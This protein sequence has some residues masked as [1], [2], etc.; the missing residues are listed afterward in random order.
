VLDVLPLTVQGKVDR[1]ALPSPD[2]HAIAGSAYVEP[3][4]PVERELARIWAEV[5]G[6]DRV[7]VEDN[8]FELG[9]DSILS[10]RVTSRLRSAL[11]VDLSPRMLFTTPTVAGLATA[12]PSD[13]TSTVSAIPVVSRSG[14]LPLSFAQQRLW[15]LH[16][17]DPDSTEYVSPTVLRMRGGLDVDALGGALTA[18]VTRHESLRTTIDEVDGKGTQTVH[19]PYEVRLQPTDVNEGELSSVLVEESRRP[20]DLRTGPL[21]RLRLL[22]LAPDEHL[23][24]MMMH[25]IVTDG[26]SGGVITDEL[27]ALYRAALSGVAHELPALPVQYADFA[28]WQREQFSGEVADEQLDYWRGQ[29]AGVPPLELP[30]DRPRPAVRTNNGA[31]LAFTVPAAVGYRLRRLAQAHDSTLFMA[32]AGAC[33]VLLGRWSRQHDVALGTVTTGRERA[34]LENLIGFFV[35]TLVLRSTVDDTRSFRAHLTAMRDT[36][37]G[38]F[39]HQDIPFERLVDELEPV[40]DVSRTPLFQVMVVLQN[41]FGEPMRLPGLEVTDVEI[42]TVTANFDLVIGFQELPDGRLHGALTYNTDLFDAATIDRMAAHLTILLEQ[43]AADPDRPLLGYELLTDDERRFVV[44]T[45]N[46]TAHDVPD[47]TLP[48][49]LD[50]QVARTPDAPA[51]VH[52]GGSVS[53]AEL[54]AWA[55]R[56]A[57]KL[58]SQ[59]VGP[60]T[61]VAISLP[62][63]VEMIVAMLAVIKA[64][65]AYLP[66]EPDYPAERVAFMVDETR[67]AVVLD[68]LDAVRAADG[69]PDSSPQLNGLSPD[70]VVYVIYTSGSTGRPKGVTITHGGL[71]NYLA[72]AVQMYPSLSELAI[73]HSP[74]SFDLTVT[75]LFGP[76]LVG[77]RIWVTDLTEN[78]VGTQE[79]CGFLKV[80]PSHIPLLK[81]LP[82][83]LS[84][85]GDLVVG[86]E[87]LLGEV[88]TEF[89]REHPAAVNNEYGQTETTVGC[90]ECRFE[91]GD[92]VAAGPLAIGRP[93]WNVRL[94]VLDESLRPAPIGVVG[95]IYVAGDGVARG[96]FNRPGLTADR[97][98]ACPFGAPGERMY[99]SGDLGRK[100]ADGTFECMGRIDDQVKVRGYRVELGEIEAALLRHPDVAK[101]AVTVK[102]GR[103]LL[104]YVVPADTDTS[105]LTD[106]LGETLPEYMLPSVYV[107]L[108]ALPLTSNGKLDRD[109]LPDPER[110]TNDTGYVA[111]DGPIENAL[112]AIWAE[113]LGMERVSVQDNFFDLGGDSILSI[114][115]VSRARKAG[116]RLTTKDMFLRQTIAALAPVVTAVELEPERTRPIEGA[117]PLT[118]IQRWFFD[119]RPPNPHHFNQSMLVE[120]AADIQDEAL[121]RALEALL[122]HHDALRMRYERV[123]EDW[124]QHYGPVEAVAY[125]RHDVPDEARWAAMEDMADDVHAGLDLVT[126][127]LVRAVRFDMGEESYL[128]LAV[129][130]LVVDSVSWRIVL[131]D[132]NTAYDQATHGATIDLGG[133]TTSY[134]QWATRLIEHV[135]GGHFDAEIEHWAEAA[136]ADPL[137][138]DRQGGGQETASRA[139][140]VHVDQQA[141]NALLR[142]APSVY[143]TGINDVLLS[144]LAWA[145]SSW[146][147]RSTVSIDLE[148]HGREDIFEGVDLSRTVG[149]F[150]TMFPVALDVTDESWR[151]LIKSVRRQLRA[152]PSKGIGFGALRYLGSPAVR[153]RLTGAGPQIVFNYLGQWDTRAPD[154]QRGL[155]RA[156]HG[157]IGQEV[158]PADRSNHLLEVVA[159]VQDGQ[160]V[161]TWYYRSDVFEENT[162]ESV[163]HG[164]AEVL[165]R[166]AE[167]CQARWDGAS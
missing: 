54:N 63:S 5:L 82:D 109:A 61:L 78:P 145:V 67:P 111:P 106:F 75:T 34:E 39:A 113:V 134:Q 42:P 90:M 159:E 4:T 127:P 3:R 123:D 92:P 13:A 163:A 83:Q 158:D 162:V 17:F 160:F 19:P 22:R 76:L 91:Q 86:G 49:L 125:S 14:E 26:W 121:R 50:A 136:H 48:E 51:L 122:A 70:N 95:E 144:A 110:T 129:H 45:G 41:A 139:V 152:V 73:L 72:W 53:Y 164:F 141:T 119:K 55:N 33:Q 100:R 24:V 23:L 10:I 155:Y 28:A 153:D 131:D 71:V 64:G 96:Y 1:R 56:L 80:T 88:V 103:Q 35:N 2:G 93:A 87:F 66:V 77:G 156:V 167:D 84:P 11:G 108:D 21:V 16:Q 25:H 46:D 115:V 69:Y 44:H 58:I 29:L 124:R 7:G 133:K 94:Y 112:A 142:T 146:T 128:F 165:R 79:R 98:M 31:D 154:A 114:Q 43:I 65:G 120:L 68:T 57:H 59:G 149:W 15:F 97:F 20:F 157:P 30:T 147:G 81:S 37:L 12:L 8:F 6:V 89:H 105:G 60:E 47:S 38:A 126:G 151:D 138:V 99:R 32:L 117:V 18:L 143:R 132:L 161:A 140:V 101:A 104:A 166:I 135:E 150:T 102:E 137:P 9:G 148:G 130:H 52:T 27:G 107:G 40:R 74:A 36:V 62:R 85:T 116:L 118:P